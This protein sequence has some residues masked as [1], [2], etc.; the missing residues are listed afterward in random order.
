M[1]QIGGQI[2]DRYGIGPKGPVYKGVTRSGVHLA[3][4]LTYLLSDK[5]IKW[6]SIFLFGF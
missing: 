6:F 5:E 1:G 4:R 2:R 3:R